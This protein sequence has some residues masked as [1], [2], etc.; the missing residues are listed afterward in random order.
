M[1]TSGT[2]KYQ[3]D[4]CLLVWLAIDLDR[5]FVDLV[6]LYERRLRAYVL[7]IIGN[8]LDAEEVIQDV[9]EHVYYALKGYPVERIRTLKLRAWLYT[10]TK[11]LCYNYCKKAELPVQ[12]SLDVSE[13]DS[14]LLEIEADRS[15]EPEEAFERMER[16]HEIEQAVQELPRFCHEIIRLR[17]LEGF[18]YQ[19]IADLLNQPIGTVKV[20]VH[21][22]LALLAE[23]L[24][25]LQEQETVLQ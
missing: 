15:Q 17:L 23:K 2:N 22:G 8:P 20:Y 1:P 11:H 6:S 13:G 21:R 19:E 14:P 9:L 24:R 12:L 16:L 3:D 25:H 4:E 5:H 10:I 7:D 18:S